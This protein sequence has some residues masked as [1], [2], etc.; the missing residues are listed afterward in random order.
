[1]YTKRIYILT[2]AAVVPL[3]YLTHRLDGSTVAC[4]ERELVVCK[5]VELSYIL[6]RMR[7]GFLGCSVPEDE[8]NLKQQKLNPCSCFD[9]K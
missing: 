7:D 9:I 5:Y 3:P 6:S 8:K 1:M 2:P 4:G